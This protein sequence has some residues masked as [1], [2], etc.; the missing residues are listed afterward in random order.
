MV[1]GHLRRLNARGFTLAELLIVLAIIGILAT[2]GYPY[3][4]RY[5]QSAKLRAAATELV[6]IINGAR[7]LAITRNT[8][9][10]VTLS[11]NKAFYK[12][13]ATSPC[14]TGTTFIGAGTASD[15]SIA[16]QNQVRITSSTAT[17][18]F[19]PL[20]AASP[21]GTYTITNPTNSLT[22]A[23]VVSAAGRVSIQ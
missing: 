17:V 6:V 13:G 11:S 8:N 20:G 1:S 15:G 22:L 4:A 9:V 19:S 5:L 7:Q 14:T 2:L 10:C 12:S 3:A 16:L 18:T 21:A 23:V